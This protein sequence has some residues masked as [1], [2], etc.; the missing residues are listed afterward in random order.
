[1]VPRRCG[2]TR[3]RK[4]AAL[5]VSP[6][7]WATI[8]RRAWMMSFGTWIPVTTR[9]LARASSRAHRTTLGTDVLSVVGRGPAPRPGRCSSAVIRY[10]V[11]R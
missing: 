11:L 4:G 6:G 7:W 9:P 1:M 3:T 2:P 5:R 8:S 10:W